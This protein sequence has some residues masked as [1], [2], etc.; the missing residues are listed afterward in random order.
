ML[1]LG[2]VPS[3]AFARDTTAGTVTTS[4][5]AVDAAKLIGRNIVNTNEDT[6]GEI[7]SIVIDQSGKVRYVIVGVGGFLGICKKEVAM[8]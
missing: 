3:G 6:V 2:I 7:D 4:P 1:S 5:A 8:A